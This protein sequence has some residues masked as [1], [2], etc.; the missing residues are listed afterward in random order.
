MKQY[1]I[2]GTNTDC[3]KTYV[4]CKLTAWFNQQG[5]KTQAIKP[6]SSGCFSR[7]GSLISEDAEQLGLNNFDPELEINPW[8][9]AA[10]VSPHIAAQYA[11][12]QVSV[13]DIASFCNNKS[14]S[15]LDQLLIEGAG[16]LLVPLN[17][18]ETWLDFLL[19]TKIPVIL[20]VGMRLG[21]INHALLTDAVLKANNIISLGWIANCLDESMLALE[22]NIET[23][24]SKLSLPFIGKVGYREDFSCV[25]GPD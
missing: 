12:Q 19:L 1:F 4:T 15:H 18:K 21:C 24:V 16:G 5:K 2:T 13:Q 23:L 14:F 9:F 22:E 10:P 17:E 7:L 6:V 25:K 3:G 8:R 20:V 11:G